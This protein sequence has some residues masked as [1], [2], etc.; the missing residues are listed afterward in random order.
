MALLIMT[1]NILCNWVFHWV[2]D[3]KS[4]W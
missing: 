3:K 1:Y 4:S 2:T